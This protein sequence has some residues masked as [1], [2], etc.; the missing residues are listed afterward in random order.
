MERAL[1]YLFAPRRDALRDKR[2]S[3]FE[4]RNPQFGTLFWNQTKV[5]LS[6]EYLI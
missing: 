3:L 5:N 4:H 2:T 6:P 1:L